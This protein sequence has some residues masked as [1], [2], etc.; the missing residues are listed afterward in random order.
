MAETLQKCS[1]QGIHSGI[2]RQNLAT[3]QQRRETQLKGIQTVGATKAVEESL[4]K[5]DL[6][7]HFLQ[8][9]QNTNSHVHMEHSPGSLF[10]RP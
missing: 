5:N 8:Q 2:E 6:V 9:K 10:A 7:E 3:K 1:L 4:I